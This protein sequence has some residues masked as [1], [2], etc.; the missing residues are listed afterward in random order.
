MRLSSNAAVVVLLLDLLLLVSCSEL[1][2]R[3]NEFPFKRYG[4]RKNKKTEKKIKSLRIQCES[5]EDC[6]G[7]HGTELTSCVRRCMSAFCYNELY[8]YDELEDGEIDTRFNSFK[9]CVI[10]NQ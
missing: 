2:P 5:K 6:R 4:Y 9:G 1:P 8:A 3:I 7:L 10:E